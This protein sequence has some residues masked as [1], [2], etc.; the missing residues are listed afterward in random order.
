MLD[1][2]GCVSELAGIG[3][4]R[5]LLRPSD[6]AF[7]GFGD[8][9]EDV[10]GLVP[11]PRLRGREMIAD[12]LGT[13]RQALAALPHR[14]LVVHFDVDVLDALELPLA[15]I[16]TYATGVLLDHVGPVLTTLVADPRVVGMTV[17]E[18]N[19]D[20]DTD[21]SSIHRLV[22]AMTRVLAGND[23]SARQE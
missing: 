11:A 6:V 15:D 23:S 22:T 4:R 17:V 19:P 2:P 13:A 12:P 18:V 7:V 21:G 1:L 16:S 8:D 3:S 14:H 20:H 9:E 10:H 5:P